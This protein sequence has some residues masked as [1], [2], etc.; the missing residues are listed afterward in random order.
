MAKKPKPEKTVKT[1]LRA[2]LATAEQLHRAGRLVESMRAYQVL[3]GHAPDLPPALYNLGQIHRQRSEF[4]DAEY[5]FRRI[6]HANP[7][8]L[9][10]MTALAATCIE[11]GG[12]EEARELAR[13][14]AQLSPAAFIQM[15]CATIM[16]RTGDLAAAQQMT[17]RVIAAEPENVEGYYS[18]STLKKFRQ[19]DAELEKMTAL[20]ER[21]GALP[22]R[23]RIKLEFALG[24]AMFDIGEDAAAFS[25]YATANRLK[26]LA[27]K[28]FNIGMVEKYVDS[29]IAFFTPEF[30]QRFAQAGAVES[31]RPVFIVGMPRSGSTLTE[32]ILSCHPQMAAMGEVTFFDKSL[33]VYPNAEVPG[34]FPSDWPSITKKL[35]ES[36]SSGTL[37]GIGQKYL[38]LT[39]PFARHGA[40]LSDKM[41]FNFFNVGLIRMALPN[42]KIIHCTRD[43]VSIGLSIWRLH[44]YAD[45]FWAYDM[46]DIARYYLAYKKLMAHWDKVF[47]GQI[48][49]ANYEN[50]VADQE[51]E[52]R[53]LLQFCGLPFDAACLNF[54]END[55]P[56][57]TAS[58]AQ[59]RQGIYTGSVARW[60]K[61]EEYLQ[62][63]IQALKG[64][65]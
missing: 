56:V 28:H 63:M 15:R 32:Q 8:D 29:I 62:P 20:G 16:S 54:H 36:I 52:T 61:Y 9:E 21:A 33:P 1:D 59:V 41:L 44:F 38:Q 45:C 6:L 50:M 57:V 22:D 14:A 53:R 35:V 19:G 23:Q 3:L 37:D 60:K 30:V 58:A 7:N 4:Q 43:P 10:A 13:R 49:E 42:A 27:Y 18:L 24:N 25:H 65:T 26:R 46:Q 5:C 55:R 47:P 11:L 64:G 31:D 34:L 39:E 2:M 17:E 48:F 12:T 40:K 51:N